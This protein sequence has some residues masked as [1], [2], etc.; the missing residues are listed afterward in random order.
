MT[1]FAISRSILVPYWGIC[2]GAMK[3]AN[4]KRSASG[5]LQKFVRVSYHELLDL[6]R[7]K[8]VHLFAS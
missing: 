6:R 5:A 4:A 2:A 8:T 1:L 7:R 3:V